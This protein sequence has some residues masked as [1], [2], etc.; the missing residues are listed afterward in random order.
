M[1]ITDILN[2]A[3]DGAHREL[4]YYTDRIIEIQ[5]MNDTMYEYYE[6][7]RNTVKKD[8]RELTKLI[9]KNT[10]KRMTENYSKEKEFTL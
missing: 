8:I 4:E 10:E 2:Y 5:D 6:S 1:T 3:L 7:L 9:D